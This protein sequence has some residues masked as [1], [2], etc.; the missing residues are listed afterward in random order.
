MSDIDAMQGRI[1]AALDR[2]GQGLDVLA[3]DKGDTELEGLRQQLDDELQANAQL[4]QRVTQL[5]ARA[6]EA[7]DEARAARE[8]QA[9]DAAARTAAQQERAQTMTQLDAELQSLRAANQT[10]RDNNAALR[11]ANA[12]GVAKPELINASL[13]AELDGLRAARAADRAEMDVILS[14][15]SQIIASKAPASSS[16]AA[17]SGA[18]VPNAALKED[19]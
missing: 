1:M 3:E 8:A 13:M 12:E 6:S 11:A 9:A 7:E 18:A 17:K 15:L 19:V 5:S 14:E 10:L 4:E 2:I 16:D